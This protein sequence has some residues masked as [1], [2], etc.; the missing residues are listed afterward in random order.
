VGAEMSAWPSKG[1]K[2]P[3][4]SQAGATRMMITELGRE[5]EHVKR[6]EISHKAFSGAN[7]TVTTN[8]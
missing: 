5:T 3:G 8:T 6:E 2:K 1:M 4:V 7:L